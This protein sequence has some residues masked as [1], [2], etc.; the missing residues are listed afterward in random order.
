MGACARARRVTRVL[1][2]A[3]VCVC[4][5]TVARAAPASAPAT[6]HV[7]RAP[8]CD[9]RE[10]VAVSR[11]NERAWRDKLYAS[12]TRPECLEVVVDACRKGSV[13]VS[14]HERHGQACGGDPATSPRVDS[15]RVWREGTR[16]DWYDVVD[17]AW[18]PFDKVRSKG[19][20]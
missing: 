11:L 7:S 6:A 12:W 19:G 17:D 5:C 14:L 18:R 15:F 9:G 2:L 3:G 13:D 1:A 10:D 16:M 4:V 20:R 8:G